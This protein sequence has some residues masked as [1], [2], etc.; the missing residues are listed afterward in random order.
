M[1]PMPMAA[2]ASDGGGGA[3]GV[4]RAKTGPHARKMTFRAS[5]RTKP[6][7]TALPGATVTTSKTAPR[8]ARLAPTRR[9][10]ATGGRAAVGVAADDAVA[11]APRMVWPDRLQT[12]S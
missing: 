2:S 7:P 5:L 3:V 8:L 9:P 4:R 1:K 12:N 10:A 11:A 6:R